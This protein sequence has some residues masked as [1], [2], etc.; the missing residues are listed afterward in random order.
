VLLVIVMVAEPLPLPEQPP[1]V[2]MAT[3]RLDDA[4]AATGNVLLTAA[5]AGAAVV[6]VM[7]WLASPAVVLL[8]T[9]DAAL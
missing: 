8:V 5:L 6:T 9:S 7:L 1:V 4:V 3:L 2:A